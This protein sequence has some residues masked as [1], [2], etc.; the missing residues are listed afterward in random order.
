[1]QHLYEELKTYAQSDA[2]PYHMPGHKRRLCGSLPAS[3]MELDITEIH[4][5]DDLHHPQGIL[6]QLQ[7]RAALLYGAEESFYLVNGS[8]CGVLT[9]I[10]AAL[11]GGGH[12]LMARNCHRSAYHAVYLRQL[13]VS[14]LYPSLHTDVCLFEAIEPGQVREAL[15]QNP[16]IGAVLLV[17]PTYEGR[18]ADIAAIAD[19]VHEKNLPL[20]VDEAHG[21]HLGWADGF[22]QNSC[23]LGA[24][25]V[26]HSVH[27]TLPAMTQTALLHVNGTRIDRDRLRR[28]LRIYQT[29]SPSYVLM[30]S[31]E[32]ALQVA[33]DQELFATFRHRFERMLQVLQKCKCLQFVN[34]DGNRQDIGKLVII[35]R[36]SNLTGNQLAD[37]L[38]EMYHLE[39][40]LASQDYA[41]A[42]FTIADTQEGYDRMT[43]ALLAIDAT[44]SKQS[45]KI[46]FYC[47]PTSR[48]KEQR[49]PLAVAWD[50]PWELVPL[51]E[52]V[53]RHV[54]ELIQLYPPGVPIVVPG[55]I[56]TQTKYEKI[57]QYMTEQLP[58]QGL[59][60]RQGELLVKVLKAV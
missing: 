16:E 58:V 18:I 41:L 15:E 45:E 8:S 20:I 39:V 50:L 38:R 40:E 47:I 7:Q 53:Q 59:E 14:Y 46:P 54:G 32:N 28:F 9:A 6:A 1:M 33:Q 44:L 24:D 48:E 5:F 37:R 51:E 31:I 13:Q 22:A 10:S 43:Q 57:M 23:Q 3:C 30:S 29:S 11:P 42:M 12:L 17:S 56:L 25:L 52:A 4:G 27:K 26:I 55:E 34:I 21:A 19:I 36:K 49:I 35:T 60:E 2:Y